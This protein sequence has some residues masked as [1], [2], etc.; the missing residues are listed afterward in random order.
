M[1]FLRI[2]IKHK[3]FHKPLGRTKMKFAAQ[4]T[5]Q[6]RQ[7]CPEAM[8]R[9]GWACLES[10]LAPRASARLCRQRFRSLDASLPGEMQGLQKGQRVSGGGEENTNSL[11]SFK[12]FSF[13]A[14]RMTSSSMLSMSGGSSTCHTARKPF[15]THHSQ[16]APYTFT[17][18]LRCLVNHD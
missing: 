13:Q 14:C 11:I 15:P 7:G 3:V 16:P 2:S 17:V 18:M 9:P 4:F 10:V 8:I 12:V 1:R 5:P 6:R